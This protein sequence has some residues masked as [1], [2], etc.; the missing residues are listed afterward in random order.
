MAA[1][2]S[3]EDLVLDKGLVRWYEQ[4][5]AITVRGLIG[6][7]DLRT[8][9]LAG[10][11]GLDR[12]VTW[13]HV[14]E[15]ADPTEWL[16][17][18]EL[19]M[20]TGLGIPEEPLA[21]VHYVERLAQGGLSGVMIGERMHAPPLSREML[22]AADRLAL[23]IM[24]TAYEVPFTAVSRM[25]ADANQREEHAR[26]LQTLQVY[27]T[28]R[29][30]AE[31]AMGGAALLERLSE[32]VGC[33]LFVVDP[34]TGRSPLPDTM[35]A[36]PNLVE[37]LARALA[38]RPAP[39]PAVLRL[40]CGEYPA[41][42]L[43]VPAS[44]DAILIA[45]PR[46]EKLADLFVL[47]HVAMIVALE[48]ERTT[49]EHERRRRLGAELLAHMVDRRIDSDAAMHML[50][51]FGLAE[52]PWVIAAWT[53]DTTSAQHTDLHLRLVDR[54]IPHLLLRRLTTQLA[55]LPDSP[56]AID[57]LREE[58]GSAVAFGLSDRLERPGRAPDAAREAHWALAAAE[59]AESGMVRYGEVAVAS[60]FLPRTL[61]DAERAVDQ[62]LGPLLAYDAAHESDLVPSLW[63][64]LSCNRSWQRAAAQ[65]NIHKQTLVYRMRR[66]EQLSGRRLDRTD[67]VAELWFALMAA[68][69]LGVLPS[70]T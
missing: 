9:L 61:A 10:A 13:A 39:R 67:H 26:L 45:V 30:A 65:L 42:S 55:L 33:E 28:A 57:G 4:D 38:R 11:G 62:I 24:L 7:P 70:Q 66:V 56:E 34:V 64:F 1:G 25:V 20:T 40:Q 3:V 37:Q 31:G 44:R 52:G 29:V 35:S 63:A 69:V 51:D 50:P 58:L 17:G 6:I 32:T 68:R 8:R 60:P 2:Q 49:A 41:V 16:S 47:R 46:S 15:L 19:V 59:A 18:G 12:E 53:L 27:E 14:C 36:P 21:Q 5:M 23:P 43:A 54:G 48:I 22:E